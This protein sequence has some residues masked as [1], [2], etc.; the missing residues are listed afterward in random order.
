MAAETEAVAARGAEAVQR[1]KAEVARDEKEKAR[2]AA[3][4]QRV[5]AAGARDKAERALYL[6][7]INLAYQYWLANNLNQSNRILDLCPAALRGWEWKDLN[8]LRHADLLTLPGNGQFTTVLQFSKD[9]KRLAAF[10]RNR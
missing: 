2:G 4:A 5:A 6:N 3:E 7:R 9:G 10:A 1:Q 8:H